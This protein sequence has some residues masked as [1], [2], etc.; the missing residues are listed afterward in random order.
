MLGCRRQE[1]YLLTHRHGGN[2]FGV[3]LGGCVVTCC[4]DDLLMLND[5]MIQRKNETNN[6]VLF[7][8]NST[9]V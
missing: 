7:E 8:V 3:D 5:A 2:I 1:N 9:L 4:R 6:L